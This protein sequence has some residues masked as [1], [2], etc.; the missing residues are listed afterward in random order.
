STIRDHLSS[1]ERTAD[2]D[3]LAGRIE[4]RI[5]RGL[6]RWAEADEGADWSDLEERIERK[7]KRTVRQWID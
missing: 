6:A 2:P 7:I 5:K 3:D 4:R 1:A